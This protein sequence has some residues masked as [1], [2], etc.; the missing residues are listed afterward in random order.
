MKPSSPPTKP[1]QRDAT[2]DVVGRYHRHWV[3]GNLEGVLSLYHP[4]I[5]YADYLNHLEMDASELRD[6]VA[7]SLPHHNRVSLTHTD[8]IRAD[9]DTAFI[10]Y[11][12][13]L[14]NA[15]GEQESY[16]SSEAIRVEDGLIIRIDE[17]ASPLRSGDGNPPQR[18][19]LTDL[20]LQRLIRD[21]ESY[22][23]TQKPY[24][25]AELDL[26]RVAADTGY[27]R[28]QVSFALNQVLGSS[29][30]DYVNKA[31]INHLLEIL[32]REPG[33]KVLDSALSAGFSST[34]TLY[35]CFKQ[36]TGLTPGAYLKQRK[37]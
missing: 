10:Q 36:H 25:K 27:T 21:L 35:K 16:R 8:R 31:R 17:Y 22:F 19:G 14:T 29:F 23:H 33:C 20:C 34:S 13:S 3:E 26:A 37:S 9:G 1:S 4:R 15:R 12:Y 5:T 28:N 2:L 18:I 6:Y 7:F 11:I 24:L 32:D 30:Y